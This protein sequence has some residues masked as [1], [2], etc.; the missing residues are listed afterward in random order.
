MKACMHSAASAR[1]ILKENLHLQRFE[2][3]AVPVQP[4][5]TQ[6]QRLNLFLHRKSS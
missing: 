5:F 4:A 2:W 3:Y 1:R 6:M